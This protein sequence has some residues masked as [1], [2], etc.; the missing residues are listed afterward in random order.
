MGEWCIWR[1]NESTW[2]A[3]LRLLKYGDYVYLDTDERRRFAQVSHEYLIEQL[4][5]QVEG[6]SR[7]N[8]KLNFDHPIKELIWTVP[9]STTKASTITSQKMKIEINGHDRFAFQNREY[10][11]IKQPL[12]HHTSVPGYNIKEKDELEMI[13]PIIIAYR[14]TGTT[15][16]TAATVLH[17]TVSATSG[18]K[19]TLTY[20]GTILANNVGNFQ[21]VGDLLSIDIKRAGDGGNIETTYFDRLGYY[22]AG[23]FCCQE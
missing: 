5:L 1:W 3:S 20:S 12:L 2:A 8:Y 14:D 21:K 10:F 9:T 19:T 16:G 23:Y 7:E 15:S 17:N 6:S 18:Q 4:Q 11:H 22:C 13:Q